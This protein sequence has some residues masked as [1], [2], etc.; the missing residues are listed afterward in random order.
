MRLFL[1]DVSQRTGA[2]RSNCPAPWRRARAFKRC[3]CSPALLV[4]AKKKLSK[5]ACVVF[6]H[7]NF[8]NP[9]NKLEINALDRS[10]SARLS[11]ECLERVYVMKST[12]AMR[13][14]RKVLHA[15][16]VGNNAVCTLVAGLC[17]WTVHDDKMD[18]WKRRRQSWFMQV[19]NYFCNPRVLAPAPPVSY[20]LCVD[21]IACVCACACVYLCLRLCMFI[22]LTRSVSPYAGQRG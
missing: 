17:G 2:R 11:C 3:V 12:A 4:Q 16:I 18:D 1:P 6:I 7:P 5:P 14:E 22:Y 19:N 9:K 15:W 8:H 20:S 10:W 21:T 13:V